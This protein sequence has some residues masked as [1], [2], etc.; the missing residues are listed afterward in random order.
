V[1]HDRATPHTARVSLASSDSIP[2]KDFV[3]R[4]RVAGQS[5]K[6]AMITQP[7][8]GGRA[9]GFFSML[10]VPPSDLSYIE[11]GPV[12]VVF[13]IDRSGSMEGDPLRQAKAAVEH[14]LTRLDVDDTFQII[15]FSDL[16]STIGDE[17]LKA[18]RRNLEK[19]LAYV[20]GLQ[21][22]GGTMMLNGVKVA[23]SMPRDRSRQRF[24]CFLTDGFIGNDPEVI[25]F[26][27]EHLGESRIMTMGVGT[28]P[29]RYLLEG[30]A[31]LGRGAAAF[32]NPGDQ[33]EET[34][35]LFL[36]RISHPALADLSID[37]G[38]MD[39]SDVYPKRLPDLYAGRPVVI[40]GRCK[41]TPTGPIRITG[42]AGRERLPT[43]AIVKC[44]D[45][46]DANTALGSL[47][48]RH[49]IEELSDK[50]TSDGDPRRA[51][52]IRQTALDYSLMSAYTA[53]IAVDSMTRTA[54]TYGTT[55]VQPVP[56]PQGVRYETTVGR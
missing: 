20:R 6:S 31:R 46:P 43:T 14:T 23:L 19:G 30:L 41:G 45:R 18:T 50:A 52:Q 2:N 37:W 25:G 4:Y 12:E 51:D 7:D 28:S 32:L 11:R 21:A 9:G 38:G 33:P 27:R 54:G 55:V 40:T 5:V 17:P 10:L 47:W 29:N 1:Q 34:M 44:D 42:R 36:D 8:A 49:R 35:D 16:A 3:L 15:D 26:V 39:V 24:V 13:L 48:A 56:V 22:G 53:F